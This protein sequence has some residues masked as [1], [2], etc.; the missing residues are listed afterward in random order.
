[1]KKWQIYIFLFVIFFIALFYRLYG[2]FTINPPFWVDEFFSASQANV[3]LKYGWGILNNPR[4]YI[5]YHNT[6]PHLFIAIFFKMLGRYEWIARLP[7]VIVGSFV[8]VMIFIVAKKI[9]DLKTSLVASLLT[10]FSYIEIVW[11]RQARGYV[12]QQLLILIT[13]YLYLKIINTKKSFVI[14]NL[15]FIIFLIFGVLIH[16]MYYIVILTI[17]IHQLFINFKKMSE[18]LKKPLL[19]LVIGLF[20]I[21]ISTTGLLKTISYFIQTGT[22]VANNLWYYHSFLWRE[23]GLITFLAIFGFVLGFMQKRKPFLLILIYVIFHLLFISFVF[24]PYI[25]RYL[26]PIFPIIF[27]AFSYTLTQLCTL[28]TKNKNYQTIISIMIVFFI[29]GNGYKFVNKPNKYYSVNHDFREIANIDWHQI[30][31]LVKQKINTN[32]KPIAIIETLPDRAGWYLG[33]DYQPLYLFRWGNEHGFVNGIAK[34]TAYQYNLQGEKV[35][36][37][38]TLRLVTELSDLI[39]V[40]KK[41]PQGFIFIDDSSLSQEIQIYAKKELKKEIYL[42]H[43]PLDDNP[44]SI[45]PA[46]LYS[47]GLESI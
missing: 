13:F 32:S 40:V 14:Y 31:S 47:W 38:T 36:Q 18:L 25:S 1:M 5:E 3:Y 45:W 34:R 29:I 37:G 20:I 8:P 28:F 30:Y 22:F 7:F 11:S 16:T 23:Y 42:D 43:Y 6:I 26:L 24:K 39:K 35:L 2:L 12:L 41:Y 4:I 46:T 15:I 9:T 33:Y 27:I 44:Y 19:Y 21:L 17:V 10:T